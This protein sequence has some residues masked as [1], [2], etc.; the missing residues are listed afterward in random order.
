L[1]ELEETSYWLE[2]LSDAGVIPASRLAELRKEADE[3]I[4]ILVASV[5]TAKQRRQPL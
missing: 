1:Q 2:L 5:R 4:A 3:L